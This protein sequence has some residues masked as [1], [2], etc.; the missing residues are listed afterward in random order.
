MPAMAQLRE[1]AHQLYGDLG[2]MAEG[3]AVE[4]GEPVA[5]VY[6]ELLALAKK[7]YPEDRLISTLTPVGEK[8]HPRVLRALTGQLGLVLANA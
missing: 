4:V 2:Y 3:G 8:M 7:G 1:H 6:N 5:L